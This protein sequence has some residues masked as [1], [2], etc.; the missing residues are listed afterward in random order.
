MA[1]QTLTRLAPT[2]RG[3]PLTALKP[4]SSWSLTSSCG[5]SW[6]PDKD[7]VSQAG[8]G[9]APSFPRL[10]CSGVKAVGF[11]AVCRN[12]RDTGQD[13]NRPRT[14]EKVESRIERE[15]D[16]R[17]A[18]RVLPTQPSLSWHADTAVV[19]VQTASGGCFSGPL[20]YMHICAWTRTTCTN[21]DV[22]P[23]G[24]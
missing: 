9:F 24:S 2:H 12:T 3:T 15:G 10:Q 14:R 4:W 1:T 18:P 17:A 23:Q 5:A 20:T 22:L 7:L 8:G 16:A 11:G 6:T 13:K 19:D 21:L